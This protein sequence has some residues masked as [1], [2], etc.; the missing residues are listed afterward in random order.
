MGRNSILHFAVL[1][2]HCSISICCSPPRFFAPTRL[3]LLS[4]PSPSTSNHHIRRK[5][6]IACGKHPS[7]HCQTSAGDGVSRST[8]N[9]SVQ[10]RDYPS[11]L[12][13]PIQA[14]SLRG[15]LRQGSPPRLLPT[16]RRRDR[17]IVLPGRAMSRNDRCSR[18]QRLGDRHPKILAMRRG[19]ED[20]GGRQAI[21]FFPIHRLLG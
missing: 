1:I 13:H 8:P 10:I 21:P 20:V 3:F 5:L 4:A 18:S 9:E 17:T 16:T 14:R 15:S 2:F 11:S 12:N 7:I 19:Y 6:S